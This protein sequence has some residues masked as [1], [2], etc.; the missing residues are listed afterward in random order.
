LLVINF[1]NIKIK[2][3][4]LDQVHLACLSKTS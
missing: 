2:V 4:L 1:I 3:K